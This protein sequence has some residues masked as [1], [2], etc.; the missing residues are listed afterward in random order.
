MNFP[1]A[2][3]SDLGKLLNLALGDYPA[4]SLAGG[5]PG[6]AGGAQ[7]PAPSDVPKLDPRP[8]TQYVLRCVYRRPHCCLP[9]SDIVSPPTA[10]FT[11]ASY[12]DADAPARPIRIVMPT[13]TSIAGLC[14]FN[15]NVAFLLSNQ[16]RQQMARATDLKSL[17]N[18][19]LAAE[20]PLDLGEIC[21][22][23]IPIITI[24][25]LILLMIIVNLLNIIFW[26]LPLFR[27]CLPIRLK[28]Q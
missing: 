17:T 19:Q 7:L 26:W 11:L 4:P 12:F 8:G 14:K 24:C 18:S 13:D 1:D 25:A 22:F 20:Q 9:S 6:T 27:I 5:G 15:K 2:P 28:S 23:S 10:P 21:L 3:L 16:L